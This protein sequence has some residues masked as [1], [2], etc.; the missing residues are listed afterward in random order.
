MKLVSLLAA[1]GPAVGLLTDAGVIDFSQAAPQLPRSMKELLERYG[2]DL[3]EAVKTKRDVAPIPLAEA[4]L[5]PVIPDP[6]KIICIGRNYAAHAAEGGAKPLEYPDIF[7]RVA[8][9]L[10]AHN[11][12]I[13]RPKVSDKLDYEA[14]LVFIVGQK[15]RHATEVDALDAIAGYSM[16][17]EGSVRDYQ[18]KATQWTPGKNFDA[19]GAFGPA[20]VTADELPAAMAGVRIQTRLNGQVMQDANTDE[21]IFPVRKL[22]AILSEIMTLEPGDIVATGTPAGVGYPRNPPVFM[23]PGDTVEVE[24]DGLG[25]LV[26]TIVD[27]A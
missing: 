12:P 11:R 17:N 19:T 21:L 2:T 7:L 20:L 3:T 23:K 14:E 15:T 16:F 25:V 4:N 10:V 26:N 8:T 1:D 18:R 13:V 9:S 6:G 27:E 22:V 24:V 5:L